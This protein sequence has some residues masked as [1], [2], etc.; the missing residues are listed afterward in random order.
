MA[1]MCQHIGRKK[2]IQMLGY[3]KPSDRL[4]DHK[5]KEH[6]V[7]CSQSDSFRR[8]LKI[9]LFLILAVGVSRVNKSLHFSKLQASTDRKSLH[10][11]VGK[12]IEKRHAVYCEKTD[13]VLQN[14]ESYFLFQKRR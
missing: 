3:Q 7:H 6:D 10:C 13:E 1:E 5:H 2:D 12:L 9:I 8:L 14:V 4:Q 11:D